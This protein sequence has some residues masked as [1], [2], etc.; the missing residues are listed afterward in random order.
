LRLT[1]RERLTGCAPIISLNKLGREFIHIMNAEKTYI[2]PYQRDA[3]NRRYSLPSRIENLMPITFAQLQ[4]KAAD[5]HKNHDR[6]CERLHSA[7]VARD[8]IDAKLSRALE[9]FQR[10]QADAIL[11]DR[12]PDVGSLTKQIANLRTDLRAKEAEFKA[13]TDAREMSAAAITTAQSDMESQRRAAVELVIAPLRDEYLRTQL[14]QAE[15]AAELQ[16]ILMAH[17]F[18]GHDLIVERT[19]YT[20]NFPGSAACQMYFSRLPIWRADLALAQ[21]RLCWPTDWKKVA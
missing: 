18:H 6:I 15:R 14:I 12:A 1:Y 17:G 3:R 7:R 10:E 9:E 8:E 16:G 5:A 21:V 4:R 13:A 19:D 20:I 11:Q 2:V